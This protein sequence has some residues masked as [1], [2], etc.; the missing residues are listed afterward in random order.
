MNPDL[1]CEATGWAQAQSV[2]NQFR[3]SKFNFIECAESYKLSL[4]DPV[5]LRSCGGCKL[6]IGF[7]KYM[8]HAVA[9]SNRK[10]HKSQLQLKLDFTSKLAFANLEWT[11]IEILRYS[12]WLL[13]SPT[14]WVIRRLFGRCKV[15][16]IFGAR[17]IASSQYDT[18]ELSSILFFVVHHKMSSL[19]W[20]TSTSK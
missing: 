17:P 20:A 4:S 1:T 16:N 18:S 6:L 10:T 7:C 2:S 5:C 9:W 19:G 14:A 11:L 12:K 8:C 15:I 3:S 13:M